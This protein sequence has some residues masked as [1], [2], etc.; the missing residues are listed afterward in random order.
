[1]NA[2]PA[3]DRSVELESTNTAVQTT[4]AGSTP[5]W[6]TLPAINLNTNTVTF[7][8]WIYPNVAHGD[9]NGLLTTR[10]GSTA[11]A[12]FHFTLDNQI[13]Y[14]W[15]GGNSET[16]SFMSEL[17]PP[18]SQWSFVARV[19]DPLNAALYLFNTNSLSATNNAI[20]HT[21]EAW[22]GRAQLGGDQE[23]PQWRIFDGTIDEVAVFNYAFTPAQVLVLYNSAF[24]S[25]VTPVTL[26]IQRLGA[27]VQLSWTKGTLLEANEVT[28]P[29]TTN[30]ATSPYIFAPA[31]AKKFFRVKVQ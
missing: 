22:D 9:Y 6:V 3:V 18:L 7:T 13:G 23:T 29:Y 4:A 1:M 30:N 25:S 24:Q 20:P 17:R 14:T 19:I 10:N 26:D 12:G 5:S 15:N 16:W 2:S 28:G 8:A 31:G 27:N 21:S 11:A